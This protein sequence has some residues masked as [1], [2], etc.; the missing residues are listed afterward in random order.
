MIKLELRGKIP[1]VGLDERKLAIPNCRVLGHP[2][3]SETRSTF[4]NR[5]SI[6]TFRSGHDLDFRSNV[7]PDRLRSTYISFE[8]S[9]KTLCL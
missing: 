8:M 3:T 7:Q 2:M 4:Q 9:K 6:E 1:R 5:Y